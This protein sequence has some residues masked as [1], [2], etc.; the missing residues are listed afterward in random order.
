MLRRRQRRFDKNRCV[1]A[2]ILLCGGMSKMDEKLFFEKVSYAGG[3]AYLVGGA[4]RDM[5]L[6][7]HPN[8]RDYVV[9]GMDEE[10]FKFIFP[11]AFRVGK[12][13]PVYLLRIDG[14]MCE[15]SFARRE[16]KCGAGY[17][18]FAVDFAPSVTIEEDLYRRDTTMN[19]MAYDAVSKRVIDPYGGRGDISDRVIRATSEHFSEDPVRALRAARQSAQFDFFVEERTLALM[20]GCCPELLLEPSERILAET[21]R[22]VAAAKPSRYFRVLNEAGLLE[23]VFPWIY[24]LIGKTQPPE[25]HPEGDAFE[26]TMMALDYAAERT[27]RCEVRFAALM[28]DI[29]KGE[30]PCEMLPHHYEHESRGLDVLAEMNKRFRFRRLWYRCAE[31]AI[32]EHMRPAKLSRP[33]KIVDLLNML[34]KHPIGCGGF[35]LIVA[36]DNKGEKAEFLDKYDLYM[37]VM[38]E[39]DMIPIPDGMEPSVRHEWRRQRE[40]DA[41]SRFINSRKI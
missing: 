16:R 34:R 5:F 26:H 3:S 36:A 12:S 21:E 2:F 1:A 15:V 28:H 13:F 18:G 25:Y 8:D 14:V 37:S 4:V 32:R 27:D 29:G 17:R 23:P 22:A 11:T 31:F 19:S 20:Q 24:R 41:V 30:T 33:S 10:R 39:A 40:I 7:G 9:C 6:S 38:E 35:S